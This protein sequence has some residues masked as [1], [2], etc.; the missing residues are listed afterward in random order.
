MSSR[1]ASAMWRRTAGRRE[2]GDD[3]LVRGEQAPQT[4]LG[5]HHLLGPV[6]QLGQELVELEARLVGEAEPDL[7][8]VRLDHGTASRDAPAGTDG[9]LPRS[10]SP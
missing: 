6:D 1:A 2:V 8:L 5:R 7:A 9:G 4:A 3:E 10:C